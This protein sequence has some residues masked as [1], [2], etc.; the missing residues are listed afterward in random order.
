MSVV[1]RARK[2]LAKREAELFATLDN[3]PKS[4]KS[5]QTSDSGSTKADKVDDVVLIGTGRAIQRTVEL[6]AYFTRNKDYVVGARTRTLKAIDDVVMPED[7]DE[8]DQARVRFV[9]CLE[10]GIRWKS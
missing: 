9:S 10:V 4:S 2:A 5:R 6:G 8:E 1:K 3:G 7:V